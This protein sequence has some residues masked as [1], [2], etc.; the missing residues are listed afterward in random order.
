MYVTGNE[1]ENNDLLLIDF[2]NWLNTI[3]NITELYLIK[4]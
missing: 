4:V 3:K 2:I 1:N